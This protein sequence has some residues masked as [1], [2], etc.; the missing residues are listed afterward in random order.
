MLPLLTLIALFWEKNHA[1]EPAAG[2]AMPAA[3][4]NRRHM[5]TGVGAA[6][7]TALTLGK[8]ESAGLPNAGGFLEGKEDTPMNMINHQEQFRDTTIETV[9][10]MRVAQ[11]GHKGHPA[12]DLSFMA[13]R[14]PIGRGVDY[15]RIHGADS[16][17]GEWEAGAI[18]ADE[19]LAYVGAH[20]TNGNAN[21]L[22]CIVEG[23]FQ[24]PEVQRK[25]MLTGIEM[26][27]LKRLN[28][29]LL[30]VAADLKKF[31]Y[32]EKSKANKEAAKERFEKRHD[33]PFYVTAF[34]D[35]IGGTVCDRHYRSEKVLVDPRG[36]LDEPCLVVFQFRGGGV[37]LVSWEP[38]RR[39]SDGRFAAKGKKMGLLDGFIHY[40][41]SED[42]KTLRVL[43]RVVGD[44]RPPIRA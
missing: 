13:R 6:T 15:W 2:E 23:M 16:Y 4:I 37:H 41:F 20:P 3:K 35:C 43:G 38:T 17:S 9:A 29:V 25:G 21:L 44:R 18:L 40:D 24:R 1:E 10:K 39:D 42:N 26:A 12:D 7:A 19:Y 14:K 11:V 22:H 27:F 31:K 28:D 34:T 5:L 30:S 33:S 36:K 32:F 8:A